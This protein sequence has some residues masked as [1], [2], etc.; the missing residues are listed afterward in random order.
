MLNHVVIV[1]LCLIAAGFIAYRLF[2]K[3]EG[4]SIFYLF[5]LAN[6]IF[7][8]SYMI[9]SV[10]LIMTEKYS[11][12]SHLIVCMALELLILI[13][14][15]MKKSR[16]IGKLQL[17]I[18]KNEIFYI[19]SGGVVF[20][21]LRVSSE[22]IS[23]YGDMGTYFQH[24]I[25]MLK[26]G[27]GSRLTLGEMY[28]LSEAV[29]NHL[30]EMMNVGAFGILEDNIYQMHAIGTWCVI[31]A[32]FAKLF[33]L[34]NCMYGVKYL[35]LLSYFN[36][37]YSVEKRITNRI[38]ICIPMLMIGTAPLMLYIGKTNLSE[39]AVFFLV[40][41]GLLGVLRYLDDSLGY[42]FVGISLGSISLVHVNG[43]IYIPIFML[44]FFVAGILVQIYRFRF[45]LI[46]VVMGAM[47]M[48]SMW[49]V[50]VIA[51][52]YTT[53]QYG[54]ISSRLRLSTIQ[55][56]LVLD[57]II[58]TGLIIQFMI[59]KCKLS[60]FNTVIK[61][62]SKFNRVIAMVGVCIIIGA[63]I[64]Y[65]YFLC[66]SDKFVLDEEMYAASTWKIRNTYVN[67]GIGAASYLNII[68]ILRAT[69][70]AGGAFFLILPFFKKRAAL[71]LKLF[72]F[73]T[74][75]I[76][77]VFTI[78]MWDTPINY[79][80]SRYFAPVLIPLIVITLTLALEKRRFILLLL[81]CVW[82]F[83]KQYIPSMLTCATHYGQ[84]EILKDAL[85]NIE[86][87]GIVMFDTYSRTLLEALMSDLHILNDNYCYSL[88]DYDEVT[89]AYASDNNIYIISKSELLDIYNEAELIF[90]RTY[91]SQYSLGHGENG[92][93]GKIS[94]T[95][96][97]DMYIYQV[98][99][100]GRLTDDATI[101][102]KGVSQK[103]GMHMKT[104]V[105]KCND[106]YRMRHK[107]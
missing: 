62:V 88:D 76:M 78:Y 35:F 31:P 96:E 86:K 14:G 57:I 82:I 53:A 33:G 101:K 6:D 98:K 61:T 2:M 47:L 29:D 68:N 69:G 72:Y 58:I 87:N 5:I 45:W 26:G 80:A 67:T 99:S 18:E 20:A 79:Y 85:A 22:E 48:F 103:S 38:S 25:L 94:G 95:Y 17:K 43:I 59:I 32:L 92:T 66:F 28:T 8:V 65:G 16:T 104:E 46:N 34:F 12:R 91:T 19:L 11:I 81:M 27:Y 63:S 3:K 41:N 1:I 21:L 10:P 36:I 105:C 44:A 30:S 84:Y 4:G 49:Y 23:S 97:I 70:V 37:L 74:L 52:R 54:V 107:L 40:S 100:D 39:I 93:Y 71:N 102:I 73:T 50:Y 24:M 42:L 15:Y 90:C 64:Y 89:T 55:T 106:S 83:N 75:L 60:Y 77:V 7:A 56:F 9:S 13:I 51:P